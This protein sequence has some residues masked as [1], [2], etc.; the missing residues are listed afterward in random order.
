MVFRRWNSWKWGW[1]V[2]KGGFLTDIWWGRR[3]MGV[4]LWISQNVSQK[5]KEKKSHFLV[6]FFRFAQVVYTRDTFSKK[7][8]ILLENKPPPATINANNIMELRSV[9][10]HSSL[11]RKVFCILRSWSVNGYVAWFFQSPCARPNW[12]NI[13]RNEPTPPINKISL[14][15]FSY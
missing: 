9:Q 2:E 14:N 6:I 4:C 15:R 1:E 12:P 13:P 5:K 8:T 11:F 10:G 7:P 3:D